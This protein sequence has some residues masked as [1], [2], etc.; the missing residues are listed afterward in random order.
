MKVSIG[1]IAHNE[2]R[3][4]GKLLKALVA[5]PLFNE[6]IVVASGCTDG[7]VPI[8]KGFSQVQ[9]IEQKYRE[10]KAS[11][12]NLFLKQATGD[13][14]IIENGDTLPACFSFKYLLKP[15]SDSSVGITG[16]HWIPVDN[17]N[18]K[19]GRLTHLLWN[20]HHHISLKY[21]KLCELIAF[22]NVV[23]QIDPATAV[24]EAFIEWQIT[25]Q[26]YRIAYCPDA[27]VFIIGCSNLSDFLK[28]RTRIYHGHLEL[29]SQGR[30]VPTMN[31]LAV[32]KAS[33]K[34]GADPLTLLRGAYYEYKARR[35][36][37]Q[38]FNSGNHHYTVWEVPEKP[39]E[40]V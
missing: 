38:E 36:A 37:L 11:A 29:Q 27:I 21:P 31:S 34:S 10:G 1:I 14:L 22:R 15:F 13:I 40:L 8:A 5:T 18:T 7:T 25:Q 39:K 16:A 20:T 35:K 17:A 33:L 2:E 26:G 30:T 9:V 12:I 19:M 24:D 28:Q 6:I 3:S 4:I 23:N 32:L